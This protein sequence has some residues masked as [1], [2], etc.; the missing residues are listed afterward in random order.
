MLFEGIESLCTSPRPT[1][2]ATVQH[3]MPAH[4][5]TKDWDFN[6]T[7]GLRAQCHD[8]RTD[9]YRDVDSTF[10]V[11][12]WCCEMSPEAK[13]AYL[14]GHV[15]VQI[16][17]DNPDHGIIPASLMALLGISEEES[18]WYPDILA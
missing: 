8:E 6:I 14:E 3:A 1:R 13:K 16:K 5:S 18:T 9:R 12:T 15:R 17:S 10:V 2:F 7:K 4:G 11:S